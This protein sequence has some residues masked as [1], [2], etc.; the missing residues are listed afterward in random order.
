MLGAETIAIL[1]MIADCQILIMGVESVILMRQ[2][3]LKIDCVVIAAFTIEG[4]LRA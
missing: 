3:R 4:K 1:K 2:K